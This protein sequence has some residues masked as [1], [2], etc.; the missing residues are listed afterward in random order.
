[1]TFIFMSADCL[2]GGLSEYGEKHTFKHYNNNKLA[3]FFHRDRDSKLAYSRDFEPKRLR[4]TALKY[5]ISIK[6]LHSY[7]NVL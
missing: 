2:V 6:S 3:N 5:T 7:L 4:N 1:M